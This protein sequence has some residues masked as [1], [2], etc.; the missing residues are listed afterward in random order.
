MLFRDTK[1]NINS[2]LRNIKANSNTKTQVINVKTKT[3]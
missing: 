1:N 3:K 2:N